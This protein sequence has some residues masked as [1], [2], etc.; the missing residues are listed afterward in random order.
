MPVHNTLNKKLVSY[1]RQLGLSTDE[2]NTYLYLLQ[3][4]PQTVLQISRGL[5]T[6]RTKL[7]PLLE[8]LAAKQLIIAKERHYGTSYQAGSIETLGL[9]VDEQENLSHS[10]RTGLPAA[11]H[12]LKG[13]QASSPATSSIVEYFDLEG[14]KQIYWNLSDAKTD[15][16]ILEVPAVG[17]QIG[18]H[19]K[20]K[21]RQ[22]MIDKPVKGHILTNQKSSAAPSQYISPNT[23]KIE[24]ETYVYNNIVGIIQYKEGGFYGVEI[25]NELYAAQY[26]QMLLTLAKQTTS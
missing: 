4:G 23:F 1:L 12:E 3:S 13:L 24:C 21:L 5:Q 11:L 19:L 14:V 2:I 18:K 7:Y 10:L 8:E 17:K 16:Y 25:T 22:T 9:L 26:K 15:Y 6:G 20:E